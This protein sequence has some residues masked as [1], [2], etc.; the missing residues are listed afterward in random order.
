[1]KFTI[2]NRFTGSVMFELEADSFIRAN[3][4][5]ANLNGADL[6]EADLPE[7]NTDF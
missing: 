6:S 1:M 2:T 7:A 4:T 5:G 3:L